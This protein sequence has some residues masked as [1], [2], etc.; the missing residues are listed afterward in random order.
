[1]D[2]ELLEDLFFVSSK[3]TITPTSHP[4]SIPTKDR[5]TRKISH[6]RTRAPLGLLLSNEDI[7]ET[8]IRLV[9]DFDLLAFT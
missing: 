5:M 9:G 7:I 2:D 8:K 6:L 4:G 3:A 1:V